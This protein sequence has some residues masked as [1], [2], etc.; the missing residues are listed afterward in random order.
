MRDIE[1]ECEWGVVSGEWA[2]VISVLKFEAESESL[3]WEGQAFQ[4]SSISAE[5]CHTDEG[6]SSNCPKRVFEVQIKKHGRE[7]ILR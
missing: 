5:S 4:H 3:K 2:R 7:N 1:G 6:G